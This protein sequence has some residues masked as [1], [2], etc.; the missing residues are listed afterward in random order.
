M[1]ENLRCKI[2]N[3]KQTPVYMKCCNV[4]IKGQL[5]NQTNTDVLFKAC[6]HYPCLFADGA[7]RYLDKEGCWSPSAFLR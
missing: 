6:Q 7:E 5:L 3:Q 1:L 2:H 4:V